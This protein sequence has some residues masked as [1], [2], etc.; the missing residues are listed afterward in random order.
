[1]ENFDLNLDNYGLEEILQLFHVNY[2]LDEKQMK[3]AKLIA[4]KTHPDK[5]GLD[6]EIFLFFIKAFKMLEAIY[7]YRIK[8]KRN[9]HN[10][11]YSKKLQYDKDDTKENVLLLK[12]LEGKSAKEFNS[13]FNKM[14]EKVKVNDNDVD[15]GY[16][17]WFKSDENMEKE[18]IH[19]KRDM[20]SFFE[21]KKESV[22]A[23]VV[24]KDIHE[25][26]SNGGYNLS[27]E[28]VDNYDCSMFSTLQF[29][30]LKQA[31]TVTVVP[32][33]HK[34]FENKKKFADV[35]DYKRYRETTNPSMISLDQ[36]K[37]LMTERKYMN[38]KQTTSRVF[39][40]LKR[41]EEVDKS[42]KKWWSNLMQIEN[43]L[44]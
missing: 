33:T 38:E 32:V 43:K 24:H 29:Q 2:N 18:K 6:K 5:S 37:K 40:I 1:M 12:K 26:G 7:E 9:D 39:N 27:R 16:G 13:W 4:L 23:L 21:N 41:D 11:K 35:E 25:E 28:K 8:T 20:N 15:T 36:S 3:K 44:F 14:F 10:L 22:K 17:S 30:D 42:N 34:D 19:N 31:H